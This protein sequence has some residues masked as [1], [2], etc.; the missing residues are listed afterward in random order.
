MKR[1]EFGAVL[2]RHS[3]LN[4][5]PCVKIIDSDAPLIVCYFVDSGSPLV[6][7]LITEEI[8]AGKTLRSGA[9]IKGR[10]LS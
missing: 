4:F 9:Y 8:T 5:V 3:A 7:L 6:A 10:R 2:S 1:A